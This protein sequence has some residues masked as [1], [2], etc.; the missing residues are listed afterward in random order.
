MLTKLVIRNFKQFE[1]VE[2]PL[3]NPV[4]FIG[5]NNSGKTT[6]LQALALWD[7]GLRRWREKRTSGPPEKRPG[8]NI[9]RRDLFMVP[10]PDAKQLWRQLRVRAAQEILKE[11]VPAPG[12]KNVRIDVLVS[13]NTDGKDWQCGLEFDFTNDESFICRPLRTEETKQ[14]SR[15]SIP[16][17]ATDVRIAFLQPMSGLV[18]NEI[19]LDS[20]AIN[21]RLGEGRTAEVLRNLCYTLSRNGNGQGNSAEWSKLVSDMKHLFHVELEAPE[22]V[23]E[24]GEIQMAYLDARNNKVRLDISSS[25]RGLQQ[26]LLLL[27][28]LALHPGSVLLLDEPDAHLEILR[29]REIYLKLREYAR[30]SGSQLLIAS[31]SEVVLTEAASMDDGVVA[32]LGKPNA[33]GRDKIARIRSALSTVRFDE[34]YVAEQRGWVLY[35]EDHTDWSILKAFAERLDHPAKEALKSPLQFSIGNHAS[36]GRKHFYDLLEAKPDLVGFLLVDSDAKVLTESPQ[37]AEMKWQRHEIEN[38]ICQPATLR[39]FAADV[40]RNSLMGPIFEQPAVVAM[41][42]AISD[43][44][45]PAALRDDNDPW[46]RQVKAS[47][48]FLDIVIPDFYRRIGMFMDLRKAD[49]FRLVPFVPDQLISPE[50]RQALDRILEVASKARPATG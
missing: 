16:D 44:V 13:G 25:G 8:V 45:I 23:P 40:G 6:A 43:R 30:A 37:L 46:W 11:G 20:G 4:V 36:K 35:L 42:E 27:A 5:P 3:S 29:Q 31:H 38:Y 18:S 48:Q 26:T 17:E 24:R 7:L 22:Y 34:Y 15:M 47:D 32:F 14:P 49:Y 50:I 1:D 9:N 12:T 39:A 33:I 19:K 28:Y 21:V 10:A 41:N 2:I